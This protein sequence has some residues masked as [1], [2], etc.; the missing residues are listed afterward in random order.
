MMRRNTFR[1]SQIIEQV[2][3]FIDQAQSLM[4]GINLSDDYAEFELT[5]TPLP[6]SPLASL[7]DRQPVDMP[8]LTALLGS[9]HT[10][11]VQVS[12][13]EVGR[14]AQLAARPDANPTTDPLV[15]QD[16]DALPDGMLKL[17]ADD[18]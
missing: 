5:V 17:L 3:S 6:D 7:F 1:M 16:P 9:D 15:L 2:A 10:V 4:L 12:V 8:D 11:R 14:M 13:D 18:L